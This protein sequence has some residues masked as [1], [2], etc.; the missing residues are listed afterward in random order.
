MGA[1]EICNL[2]EPV[3]SWHSPPLMRYSIT[4]MLST[5]NRGDIGA[6]PVAAIISFGGSYEEFILEN[7]CENLFS[8]N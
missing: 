6:N 4:A 3:Q 8:S 7:L 5:D 1:R 2:E